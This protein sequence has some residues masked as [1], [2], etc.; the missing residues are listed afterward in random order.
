[1]LHEKSW[2]YVVRRRVRRY[3]KGE[4][5]ADSHLF[6]YGYDIQIRVFVNFVVSVKVTLGN[7][8][9]FCVVVVVQDA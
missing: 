6:I 4:L 3:T 7:V 5:L 8:C 9:V 1:M 2:L